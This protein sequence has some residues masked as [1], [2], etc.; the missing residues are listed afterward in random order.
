MRGKRGGKPN[1]SSAS[2]RKFDTPKMNVSRSKTERGMKPPN[3]LVVIVNR[4]KPTKSRLSSVK[5]SASCVISVNKAT[6]NR[7]P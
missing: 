6:K 1:A 5:S 4:D 3:K 2:P 7:S